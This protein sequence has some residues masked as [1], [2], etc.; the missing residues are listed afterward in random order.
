MRRTVA[1]LFPVALV[2]AVLVGWEAGQFGAPG[3]YIVET[4]AMEPNLRA[5]SDR[6]TVSPLRASPA[7]GDIIVFDPSRRAEAACGGTGLYVDRVIGL[8]GDRIR[9]EAG[10]FYTN[11]RP[12][13]DNYVSADRRDNRS[14][15][16]WVVKAHTY[17]VLGDN[18]VAACDS[19]RW[20]F[21]ARSQIR[22]TVVSV[23]LRDRKGLAMLSS[24]PTTGWVALTVAGI[25]LFFSPIWATVGEKV[26]KALRRRLEKPNVG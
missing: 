20:G 21:V 10:S 6:V 14:G 18:R 8:P 1:F 3:S 19:T 2:C 23:K 11:S 12:V 7:R 5:H 22:G 4:Q 17:F 24:I 13:V 9:E 15:G 16:L 25:C 26:W